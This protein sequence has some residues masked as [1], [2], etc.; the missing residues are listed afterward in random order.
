MDHRDSP[1]P[2]ALSCQ[3]R[4]SGLCS[5]SASTLRLV[6]SLAGAGTS[7]TLGTGG[8][9]RVVAWL[10]SPGHLQPLVEEGLLADGHEP[11]VDR[12]AQGRAG[13]SPQRLSV[14]EDAA[15]GSGDGHLVG[16]GLGV[17]E[18]LVFLK[19]QQD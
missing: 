10:L 13:A 16:V 9:S 1:G 11:R 19:D 8:T 5:P 17:P 7:P 3:S 4:S 18:L 14:P 6:S 2:V 12:S 15:P